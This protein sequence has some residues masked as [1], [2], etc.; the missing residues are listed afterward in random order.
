MLTCCWG[1]GAQTAEWKWAFVTVGSKQH[2]TL[3][4]GAM[5]VQSK[6]AAQLLAPQILIV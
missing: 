4:L 5:S 3:A 6:V 2:G 1:S